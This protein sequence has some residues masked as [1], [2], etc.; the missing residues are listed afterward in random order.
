MGKSFTKG[1]A[2]CILEADGRV[3]RIHK[4]TEAPAHLLERAAGALLVL[5]VASAQHPGAPPAS[6]HSSKERDLARCCWTK[7]LRPGGL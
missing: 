2:L 3:L 6:P 7:Y 4:L 5:G 1:P